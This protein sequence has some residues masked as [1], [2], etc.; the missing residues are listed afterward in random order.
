[1][2]RPILKLLL[3]AL[4][5]SGCATQAHTKPEGAP[6]ESPV[7]QQKPTK[8]GY[9]PVNGLRLYYEVHGTGG[10]TP[11]ILL[12]GGFSMAALLGEVPKQLAENR[13]V[14]AVDLQGHGRTGD[15]DR[16][17]RFEHMADDIAAL[18]QH[19]GLE[20]AD[21]MGY[22]LGGKVA[23]RTAIQHPQ[24]IRKLV[25][26]SAGFSS[27]SWY[28][29]IRA[30]FK[31]IN[32]SMVEFMRP[33]PEYQ[34]YVAVS[35]NPDGFPKLLDK[36]GELLS[37][38]YDWSNEVPRITAP[39]LLIYADHDSIS[40]AK[41]VRF[42]ELL[43]GGQKDPGWEGKDMSNARLAILPGVTHY[44]IFDSPDVVGKAKSFLVAPMPA[45]R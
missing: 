19:L 23:I 31:Q 3:L 17:L 5:L 26:V 16:P 45:S 37:S 42:F 2:P 15:I 40:P 9:A 4:V 7:P 34:T 27:D 18:I 14:I 12:H 25:V 11:L 43:G 1:M 28:P 41:M 13:Q 30:T 10:G 35:P 38:D 20:Q 8:S 22:S 6:Q 33:S 39:T 36:M 44:N 21:L 32:H 29:E 24:R